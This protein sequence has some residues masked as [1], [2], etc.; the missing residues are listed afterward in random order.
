MQTH[1]TD[2]KKPAKRTVDFPTATT[3]HYSCTPISFASSIYQPSRAPAFDRMFLSHFVSS[4]A[5]PSIGSDPHRSWMQY[6][7]D[8]L[9]TDDAPINYSIRAAT[10][11]FYGELTHDVAIQHVAKRWYIAALQT[12]RV[13][14]S[15]YL[16]SATAVPGMPGEQEICTSMML[17]YFEL[18]KP[19]VTASWLKHLSGVT[20]LLQ[21]RGPEGCQSGIT[22]LFFRSLRL[23]TVRCSPRSE[24]A[25]N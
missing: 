22:H 16:K 21:L 19:S 2:P 9:G 6:L 18:I 20:S 1:T 8:Y 12:Q 15:L 3:A 4:F 11:A 13:G 5:R 25:R 7:F 17:L 24:A 23:L 10:M 14:L